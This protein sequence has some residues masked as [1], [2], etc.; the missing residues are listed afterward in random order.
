MSL[1]VRKQENETWRECVQRVAGKQGLASECLEAFD[2]Y[3]AHG[4]DD[5]PLAAW[6]AL[7]DWDCLDFEPDPSPKA[8]APLQENASTPSTTAPSDTAA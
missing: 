1:V 4:D 5:E 8:T 6:C 3:I 2:H 7:C